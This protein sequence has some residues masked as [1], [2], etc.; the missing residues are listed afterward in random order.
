[1]ARP[2]S[3]PED[4]AVERA[5]VLFWEQG[6][7]RTSISDL[8]AAIGVGPSSIYNA[9]GSKEELFRRAIAR[10]VETH[11]APTM[12]LV[13]EESDLGVVE[14]VRKLLRGLA[15]LY[16]TE[17]QPLGCAIFQ[18]AGAGGSDETSAQAVTLEL[19]QRLQDSLARRFRELA[20][21]GEVL[22]APPRTL[23]VFLIG[24]LCGISQLACDGAS[25]ADL[26]KVADLA[27][28]S[29]AG[30]SAG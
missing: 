25:R 4:E 15:S 26:M 27:A 3:V 14:F 2:R 24:T 8:S 11:A 12:E 29:C 10:Y 17:G 18:G 21:R 9:F 7:D 1:M 16:T 23:A 30:P 28:K 19:K 22:A 6:F 13:S 5:L 20:R